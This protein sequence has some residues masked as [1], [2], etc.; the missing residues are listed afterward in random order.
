MIYLAKFVVRRKNISKLVLKAQYL[1]K[2][3]SY[4]I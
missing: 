2:I 3:I 1:L 4:P